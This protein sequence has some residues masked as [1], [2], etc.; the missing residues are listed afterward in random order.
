LAGI[1]AKMQVGRLRNKKTLGTILFNRKFYKDGLLLKINLLA[2]LPNT[3]ATPL[4]IY[5]TQTA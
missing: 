3:P 4:L 1:S 2:Y 5:P